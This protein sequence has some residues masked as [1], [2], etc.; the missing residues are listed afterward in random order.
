V[1]DAIQGLISIVGVVIRIPELPIGALLVGRVQEYTSVQQCA[2]DIS[3]HAVQ[4]ISNGILVVTTIIPVVA[5]FIV[6]EKLKCER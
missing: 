5:T 2:V 1:Y 3:N 6:M 4:T